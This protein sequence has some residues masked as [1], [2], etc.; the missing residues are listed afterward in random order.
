[1][2]NIT[3][4]LTPPQKK[5]IAYLKKRYPDL[6]D[7]DIPVV[8][9]DIKRFVKVVQKIYTEPQSQIT[10][11]EV[12]KDGKK[13]KQKVFTVDLDEFGKAID[14]TKKIN[15]FGEVYKKITGAAKNN[16]YGR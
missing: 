5:L 10:I 16:K 9:N 4:K 7:K 12:E 13:V 3:T 2:R 11:R 15:T 14:K 6:S 8:L 1:M